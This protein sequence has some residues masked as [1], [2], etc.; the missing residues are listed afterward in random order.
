MGE[1]MIFETNLVDLRDQFAL[2]LIINNEATV[3]Y[4]L[5]DK[6]IIA[7]DKNIRM[8][9]DFNIHRLLGEITFIAGTSIFDNKKIDIEINNNSFKIAITL[10]GDVL[11]NT[12]VTFDDQLIVEKLTDILVVVRKLE[13]NIES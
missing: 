11:Y 7:R 12:G 6:A 13:P 9:V 3:A 8:M 10:D 2:N 5:A 1:L 4:E